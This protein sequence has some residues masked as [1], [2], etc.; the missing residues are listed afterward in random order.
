MLGLLGI[1][2][3]TLSGC[4]EVR[5]RYHARQGNR[6]FL[7]GNYEAALTE[8]GI[9]A[10]LLPT[11]PVVALNQG[12]AC[13]HLMLPGAQTPAAQQAVQCAI[14]AF[15]RFKQLRP[16]DGRGDQ[17]LVQTLFDADR[18]ETLAG[19][20]QSQLRSQP[21]NLS[22]I[23]GLVEVYSRWD[24]WPQALDFMVRRADLERSAPEVQYSVG[25]FIWNRLFQ[26][27]GSGDKAVF[28]PRT[29]PKA[30]PP[31]FAADDIVGE[32]RI[33]LADQ[34]IAY[35]EKALSLRP[36]YDEAMA[37]LNLLYRQKSYAFFD[38]PDEFQASVEAANQWKQ[39][40]TDA[41]KTRRPLGQ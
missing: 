26:K 2:G 40:A 27:G 1:G 14:G 39:R 23:N 4:G 8:Y 18:F 41:E 6:L 29:D 11:L 38:Q 30:P 10:R 37:Y 36:N 3:L 5:A 19:L 22:A 16:D 35:L 7:Q 13:R 31:P 33:R 21:N 15:N 20:Y 17:L 28:D 24:K 32:E 34:G 9:A 25:V 12:L